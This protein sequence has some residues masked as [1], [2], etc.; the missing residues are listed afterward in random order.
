[1]DDFEEEEEVETVEEVEAE[2]VAL[3]DE[4][5][6]NERLWPFDGSR[7]L[8]SVENKSV[9]YR[10]GPVSRNSNE[11]LA[12]SSPAQRNRGARGSPFQPPSIPG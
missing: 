10:A 6:D 5:L 1:L 11:D 12:G 7:E 8:E 4:Q 9:A 2:S 3:S